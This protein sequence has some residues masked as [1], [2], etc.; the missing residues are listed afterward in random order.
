MDDKKKKEDKPEYAQTKV[1]GEYGYVGDRMKE[2]YEDSENHEKKKE[3]RY[4]KLHKK[5]RG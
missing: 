2:A 5:L 1:D 3:K 4:K